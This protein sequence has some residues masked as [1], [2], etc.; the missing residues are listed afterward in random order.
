MIYPDLQ[1][2]DLGQV[3]FLSLLQPPSLSILLLDKLH[4]SGGRR[5]RVVMW[6]DEGRGCVVTQENRIHLF[7]RA[8]V[9]MCD[10]ACLS[11]SFRAEAVLGCQCDS[12]YSNPAAHSQH[13]HTRPQKYV[14]L[15][16]LLSAWELTVLCSSVLYLKISMERLF[17]SLAS[18]WP[19]GPQPIRQSDWSWAGD[20]VMGLTEEINA[21]KS[22][23]AA[24]HWNK[25]EMG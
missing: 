4:L 16:I 15:P 18:I 8:C 25:K 13:T 19:A 7:V 10:C 21:L 3:S 2:L 11:L 14:M 1:A 23:R 5:G 12:F 24:L 9:A 6:C 20:A 17:H 22:R